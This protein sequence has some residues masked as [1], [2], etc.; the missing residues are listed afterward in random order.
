MVN[1][2]L[3]GI[4]TQGLMLRSSVQYRYGMECDPIVT[5]LTQYEF[6]LKKGLLLPYVMIYSIKHYSFQY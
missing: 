1:N 4:I 2:L 6:T 3:V 5:E